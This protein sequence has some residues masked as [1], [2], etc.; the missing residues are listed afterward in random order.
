MIFWS[1]SRLNCLQTVNAEA[2]CSDISLCW[3]RT[4]L[5][6]MCRLQ[7][8]PQTTFFTAMAVVK[9][10]SQVEKQFKAPNPCL[11]K[12]VILSAP[13]SVRNHSTTTKNTDQKSELSSE[14]V[15]ETKHYWWKWY[16]L[17]CH[18]SNIDAYQISRYSSLN[19]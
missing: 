1:I 17:W 8:I 11:I 7:L 14:Y 5:S 19:S 15:K 6:G 2:L 16:Q 13:E 3:K 10:R 4:L 9:H 12:K 18:I